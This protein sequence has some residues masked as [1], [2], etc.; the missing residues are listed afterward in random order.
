MSKRNEYMISLIVSLDGFIRANVIP[1]D[2]TIS[3]TAEE[4]SSRNRH[5]CWSKTSPRFSRS[6]FPAIYQY[7]FKRIITLEL[8]IVPWYAFCIIIIAY[9]PTGSEGVPHMS[10]NDDEYNGFY[11]L[12][13]TVMIGNSWL[14]L[15][16]LVLNPS[17]WVWTSVS[18]YIILQDR[19]PPN[20]PQYMSWKTLSRQLVILSYILCSG[21]I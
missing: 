17:I 3:R 11:I 10:T 9:I 15:R 18:K 16:P 8:D 1:G 12:K 7:C 13:G 14:V 20:L 4:G 19:R 5:C 21:S 2:G 6:S